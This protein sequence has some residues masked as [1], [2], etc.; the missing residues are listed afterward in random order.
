M[1]Q[2]LLALAEVLRGYGD[3]RSH[4]CRLEVAALDGDRC[5]LAGAVMDEDTLWGVISR[6]QRSACPASPST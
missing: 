5:A 1:E 4:Y 6:T 3:T 2:V